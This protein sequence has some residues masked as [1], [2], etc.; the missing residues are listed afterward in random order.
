MVFNDMYDIRNCIAFVFV[1]SQTSINTIDETNRCEL[2]QQV[3]TC[4]SHC[5]KKIYLYYYLPTMCNL[6]IDF[7]KIHIN[8]K[9]KKSRCFLLNQNLLICAW[10]R[11]ENSFKRSS[12]LNKLHLTSFSKIKVNPLLNYAWWLEPSIWH[13]KAGVTL[14]PKMMQFQ[15]HTKKNFAGT[16]VVI[17]HNFD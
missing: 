14:M 5:F 13:I 8:N 3:G 12:Q 1:M 6:K 17:Y 15:F 16:F 11:W 9:I 10:L 2:N 4:M 7:K